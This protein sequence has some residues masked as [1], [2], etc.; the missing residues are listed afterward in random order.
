MK[1]MEALET[2]NTMLVKGNRW[3]AVKKGVFTVFE[4]HV[5]KATDTIL[6]SGTDE[7][8]AIEFLVSKESHSSLKNNIA[9]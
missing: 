6:Y 8:V 5:R 9:D 3:L 2:Q 4:R 1:I 7:D